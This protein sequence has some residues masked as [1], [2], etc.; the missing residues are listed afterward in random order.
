[1]LYSLQ[2]CTSGFYKQR[3]NYLTNRG[4]DKAFLTTQIQRASDVPRADALKHKPLTQTETTPFCYY[5]YITLHC[6]QNV[7]HIIHKHS[8]VL[9]SSERCRNVFKNLLIVSYCHSNN[10]SDIL[11]RVQLPETDNCKNARA[12]LG[13]FRC[14]SRNCTT[15]AYI[16]HARPWQLYFL[17]CRWNLQNQISHYLQYF[18]CYLH[19]SMPPLYKICNILGKP[20]AAS[21]T[22][23]RYRSP[24]L[25]PSGS[26]IQTAVSEHFLSNS[27][28]VSHMLL[29]P[30][31]ETLRYERDC[32][33][34]QV[35]RT[36]LIKPKPSSLWEW[37]NVTNYNH[38]VIFIYFSWQPHLTKS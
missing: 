13:S 4:Y 23:F 19:D 11:V 24:I 37:I 3:T 33:R 18:Q 5:I 36:S 21:R 29:I 38:Y 17:L 15:C 26:Y 22:V 30:S 20:N 16:D 8:H 35:R 1:M 28:S 25:Y 32:L 6:H 34:K 27:H 9:Y 2:P 14:D 10:L 31:I 12:T 7:A